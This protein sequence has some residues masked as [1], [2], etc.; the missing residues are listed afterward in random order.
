MKISDADR[1]V[2]EALFKCSNLEK[3]KQRLQSDIE[4]LMLDIEKS[5]G[6]VL[7]MEKRQKQFDKSILEWK[8][9]CEDMVLELDLSQKE[10]R[11]FPSDLYKFKALYEEKL[12]ENEIQC[13]QN[14]KLSDEISDL[15]N[16]LGDGGKSYYEL[17]KSF[18]K[19]ETEK[20]ELQV[21]IE[22]AE[23]GLEKEEAKVSKLQMDLGQLRQELFRKLHEK[24]LEFENTRRC[25]QRSVESIQVRII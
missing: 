19:V 4:D 5:N 18:Q 21:A 22:S 1:Q 15:V 7:G 12:E 16:Q 9:K 24:D 13:G 23:G 2:E 6:D 20:L 11:Q 25:H 10:A 17:E 8:Q 14:K 3:S